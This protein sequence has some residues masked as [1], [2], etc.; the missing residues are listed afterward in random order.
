M[1]DNK[2]LL[3]VAAIVLAVIVASTVIL[4]A[5]APK[6]RSYGTIIYNAPGIGLFSDAACTTNLTAIDW[7]TLEPGSVGQATA[8]A[9]NIGNVTGT[10]HFNASAWIPSAA[11]QYLSVTWTGENVTLPAGGILETV[12]SMHV[13]PAITGITNFENELNVWIVRVKQP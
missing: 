12:F 3:T 6:I 4:V 2:T 1:A 9:K 8:Y 5:Y 7:G 13:D 11:A 10:L